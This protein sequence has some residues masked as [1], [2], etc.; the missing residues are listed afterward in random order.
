[1][2]PVMI[3]GSLK[4]S[5][6][7]NIYRA[8]TWH[9]LYLLVLLPAGALF[10]I[11]AM[12]ETARIPFDLPECESELVTGFHTEYSSLKYAMF[13]MGEYMGMSAMCAI[14][15]H[16]FLGGYLLPSIGGVDL[17]NWVGL[18]VGNPNAVWGPQ[19]GY[20]TVLSLSALGL[21]TTLTFIAKTLLLI[22]FFM[23]IRATEPRF[24]YDQLMRFGWKV[25]LPAGLVLV[26]LAA[27]LVVAI[28]V[29]EGGA[30]LAEVVAN[31]P[32]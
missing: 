22:L 31:V 16:F 30:K 6:I 21:S 27:L 17:T 12:A 8:E 28:D 11:S 5:A 29:P 7:G 14:A 2:V 15:V 19:E 20:W 18:I 4:I 26:F 1:L 24:R 10:L 9:P 13:P 3:V 25:L 23:W 32:R